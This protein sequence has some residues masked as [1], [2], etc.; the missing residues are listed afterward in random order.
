M[1]LALF[2]LFRKIQISYL[3]ISS[4]FT[5]LFDTYSAKDAFNNLVFVYMQSFPFIF[6][7]KNLSRFADF[8]VLKAL[9]P[10]NKKS[11]K[12]E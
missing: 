3:F 6:A 1:F 4:W 9:I 12:N 5:L 7:G 8:K 11:K 10:K 2:R